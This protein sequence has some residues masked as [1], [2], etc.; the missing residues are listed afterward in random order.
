M[1]STPKLSIRPLQV[2]YEK[3]KQ[4]SIITHF[5]VDRTKTYKVGKGPSKGPT[6]ETQVSQLDCELSMQPRIILLP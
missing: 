6:R 3:E 5:A 1:F 4:G 2:T